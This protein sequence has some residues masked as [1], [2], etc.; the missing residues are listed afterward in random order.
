MIA[1]NDAIEIKKRLPN[2]ELEIFVHGALCVSY[3]GNCLMSSFIGKRSGNR[4]K[5][6]QP[7]RKTYSLYENNKKL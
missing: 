3:S 7:C 1:V 2:L 6:A 4:G 5:C